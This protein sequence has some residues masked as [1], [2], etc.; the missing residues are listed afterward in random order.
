MKKDAF[1]NALQN[2]QI[3]DKPQRTV[4]TLVSSGLQKPNN[5]QE[6]IA[7][8]EL[9]K[10]QESSH[11]VTQSSLTMPEEKVNE[12]ECTDERL[13]PVVLEALMKA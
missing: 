9:D 4:A 11:L 2:I 8:E 3:K 7:I 1:T 12:S 6:N 10:S 13:E 5:M